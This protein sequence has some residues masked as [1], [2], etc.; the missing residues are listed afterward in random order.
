MSVNLS[1]LPPLNPGRYYIGVFNSNGIPQTIRLDTSVDLDPGGVVPVTY[2]SAGPTPILDDAITNASL[3]VSNRQP[4]ASLDVGLLVN[5]PR[6]SDMVFTLI[7]PSGTRVLLFENRGGATTNG[8]GGI[9]LRT[10]I[11]PTRT[12]GN[13]IRQYQHPARRRQPGHPVR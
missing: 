5:H 12:S 10:N 11:F 8:L 6:V 2:A 4:I 9:V 7:S 1:T 13:Y 3:F